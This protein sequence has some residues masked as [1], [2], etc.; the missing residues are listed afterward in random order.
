VFDLQCEQG[1]VFE[2]WFG[3]ADS[4][5]SQRERKLLACPVCDS[6][7]ISKK[8]SAPRLNV[9]HLRE[10]ASARSQAMAPAAA[11]QQPDISQI[12]A[13]VLRRMREMVKSAEN[14]G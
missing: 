13:E 10:D 1:H 7:N 11:P 8:L 12:Q 3:S 5:E 9:S 4:Y 14:I 6:H 2:A